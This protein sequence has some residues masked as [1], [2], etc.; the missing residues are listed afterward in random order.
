MQ[1]RRKLLALL[2]ANLFIPSCGRRSGSGETKT[3]TSDTWE[4][5]YSLDGERKPLRQREGSG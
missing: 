4:N 3:R 1:G 5:V 2:G